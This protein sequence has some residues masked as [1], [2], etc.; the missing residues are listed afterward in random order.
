MFTSRWGMINAKNSLGNESGVNLN[1]TRMSWFRLSWHVTA[2][3]IYKTISIQ[4]ALE[5][6]IGMTFV[7]RQP[8]VQEVWCTI[9]GFSWSLCSRHST[10]T[11]CL[12]IQWNIVGGMETFVD[13]EMRQLRRFGPLNLSETW[14]LRGC[15]CDMEVMKL[16]WFLL[17]SPWRKPTNGPHELRSKN[18]A[19][20][21][22]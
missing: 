7:L 1:R 22:F 9:T 16:C 10:E 2:L 5:S 15:K 17:L 21:I 13:W 8:K 4:G 3:D 6:V 18:R 11:W 14:A 20:Q 19:W 12:E